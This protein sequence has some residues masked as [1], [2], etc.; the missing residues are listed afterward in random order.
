MYLYFQVGENWWRKDGS[1]CHVMNKD[2]FTDSTIRDQVLTKEGIRNLLGSPQHLVDCDIE[3][4]DLSE[5]DMSG[6]IFERCN[7]RRANLSEAVLNGTRWLNCRAAFVNLVDSW[8]EKAVFVAT[9]LNNSSLRR[10]ALEGARFE[11]CKLTGADL[12]EIKALILHFE[13][14]LFVNAK[15]PGISFR[16]ETLRRLD[17]SQADLRKCDFR[18]SVFEHCS[19]REAVLDGSRFD[20][21]DLRGADL[22]GLRLQDASRFRGALISREQAGQLLGE[23]G[24]N[25]I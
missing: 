17:F 21:A 14:T 10:C 18:Q 4:G 5:L 1:F 16:K 9:D 3:E 2:L 19:L 22:R 12:S 25:V 6:W 7:L 8:L 15:L 23:L 20:G 13:E 24:L 11:R